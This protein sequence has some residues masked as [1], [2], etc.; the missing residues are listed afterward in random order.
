MRSSYSPRSLAVVIPCAALFLTSVSVFAADRPDWENEAVFGINKLPARATSYSFASE[1]DARAYDRSAAR[2][3]SLDGDWHF[4]FTPDSAN[5]P[6]DFS[7][8]DFDASDWDTID[9]PSCW[10]RRGYGTPI[11]TNITYPF[12]PNPPLIDRT[13]PVG[14]YVREFELPADWRDHRI[15]LH[16][17]GVSSAFYV[18]VNGERVG[19]SQDSRLPAEFDITNAILP[20][21]NRV[22]VQVFRWS[23]GSYLED[24]DHWRM[25]G[26]HREV[27][28][29][30]EP[31]VALRSFRVRTVL[32]AN[33]QDAKLQVRPEIELPV[34]TDVSGWQVS[35]QLY[36]PNGVQVLANPLTIAATAIV[37]EGY[38]QRDNVPFALL[39]SHIARPLLWSAES[40]HLYTLTL[41]LTDAR[42]REVDVRS[43]L[44]GFRDV[45]FGAHAE[46][47]INGRETLIIGVNRHDHDDINGKTVSREDMRRDVELMKRYNFNAVRTSH[48]PNDP[49]FYELCDRY[50]IYVMDEANIES[51]GLRGKI[52]N[53]PNWTASMVDRVAR[54]VIRDQNHPSIISWSLGN[55]SGTG[56]AHAAAAL[57]AQDYDPT[58][59]MHYEGAQGDP[60]HPDYIPMGD[61]S[62][63]RLARMA[64]PDDP[65]WVDV[66]SRM[67]P[68][69]QDLLELAESPY[70]DRPI[71]MC[72]YAHAMGNSLG[73]LSDYWDLVTTHPNLIGGYIW[74][75]VDQGLAETAPDGSTFFQY[76]GDYGDT[77]NDSNFC[78]NGII[79]SDQRPKPAIEESKY[80]FQPIGFEA[81]DL[82]RGSVRVL[83]RHAL[84]NLDTYTLRWTV[85]AD[86][87]EVQSGVLPAPS[88]VP[89]DHGTL[90]IPFAAIDPVPGKEYWLRVSAHL[91]A[92]TVW[93]D[94][95]HEVAKEQFALPFFTAATGPAP[96]GVAP[97]IEKTDSIITL[98]AAQALVQLDA[99]SGLV[100][101][102]QVNGAEL[103]VSPLTPNFWRV[104][105]DNDN[106]GWRTPQNRQLWRDL[107]GLLQVDAVTTSSEAGESRIHVTA[108]HADL[109]TVSTTYRLTA[110]GALT[111]TLKIEA[112]P[113]LPSLL[114]VGMT[115]EV[116]AA[117]NQATYY[118]RGPME[119]YVD[120]RHA[121]EVDVYE[122]SVTEFG[123]PYVRPQEHGNRTDVRWLSLHAAD[124]P[125]LMITGAQPL[126]MSVWPYSAETLANATH[127]PDLTTGEVTTV[128]ADLVQAGVGGNDSWSANAAPMKHYQIPAGTYEYSFT[129][130][131]T[132]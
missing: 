91:A 105:T 103:L 52:T 27:L 26:L 29:L 37:N 75:W 83:N 1:A 99:R 40:P 90:A 130:N 45:R 8:A 68:T 12:T 110:D 11:Y 48:Y 66:I 108:T 77:P 43:T 35:A 100:T 80:I 53:T 44:V 121:T 78:L 76:G 123:E 86:G 50:G 55:E 24:Q 124:G 16:F 33:F 70:I 115:F 67:Y 104:P 42:G 119:N 79:A 39:K 54:M 3:V 34:G 88:V 17:G 47:L 113:Q 120:R 22:A 9:V 19:Y 41:A 85:S 14:S 31:E 69:P 64:N 61:R 97:T 128:N 71:V 125:T 36:D 122:L 10:E 131:A 126:S 25:S 82:A 63:K 74:D 20:G 132:N 117:F 59:F 38:P 112:D 84:T 101:S 21:T 56:P 111:A 32:D 109:V 107:P 18:W 4:Q 57:W 28:L 6:T 95:G 89:G 116:P 73:N 49:Y 129:L 58:R 60:T 15:I 127:T 118:G 5:R 46:L 93:A 2:M 30:A 72:E 87:D 7:A 102:Y 62:R 65:A 114:R 81:A 106:R 92:D 96:Q 23:D 98:R 13:N 51:H 94:A